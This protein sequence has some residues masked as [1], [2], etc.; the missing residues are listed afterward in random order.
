MCGMLKYLAFC[1]CCF[2]NGGTRIGMESSSLSSCPPLLPPSS[3]LSVPP[4][5]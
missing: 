5:S 4:L 3:F 2:F 1:V